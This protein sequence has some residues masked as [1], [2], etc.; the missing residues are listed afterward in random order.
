M[1]TQETNRL[2]ALMNPWCSLQLVSDLYGLDFREGADNRFWG[3]CRAWAISYRKQELERE[4][5][6]E[7]NRHVLEGYMQYEELI[8]LKRAA[9]SLGMRSE[10]FSA[11]LRKMIDEM[12]IGNQC[13]YSDEVISS[14]FIREFHRYFDGMKG[15]IFRSHT[16]YCKRLHTSIKDE[17][18]IDVIPLFDVTSMERSDCEPEYASTLDHISLEPLGVRYKV[19]LKTRK[20]INLRPDICSLRFYVANED[21]MRE[22]LYG[23]P[24]E[25]PEWLRG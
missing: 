20:P 18:G 15:I 4:T 1:T 7:L 17:L 9:L 5:D 19:W 23:N 25:I 10:Q 21:Y 22:Y 12:M 24:P 13:D 14:R 2:S 16:G 3:R 11:I 8:T 6:D